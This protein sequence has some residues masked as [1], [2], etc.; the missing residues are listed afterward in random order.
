VGSQRKY[1]R[2]YISGFLT[3]HPSCFLAGTPI[4][5]ETGLRPIESI[6]PGD[7]VLSQ[8]PDSGELAFKVVTGK[9]VRPPAGASR[10][11]ILGE[12]ITTTLGHPLWVTGQGWEMAKHLKPGDQLHGI[13]GILIVSTIDPLPDKIEAHNLVVDDFNTYFVGNCGLLVHD[14]TY[15][16]P[17][18]A[19]VPG[20]AP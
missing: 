12:S 6:Q 2:N 7:R 5:T 13:H 4:W 3:T 15:R 1:V 14:N 17:T 8:D 20:L 9:T 18:R 11:D 10:L 19:V 16:K